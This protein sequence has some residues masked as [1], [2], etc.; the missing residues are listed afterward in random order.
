MLLMVVVAVEEELNYL[1]D[2][3]IFYR[4][5]IKMYQIQRNLNVKIFDSLSLSIY[6]CLLIPLI[7]VVLLC[8]E[9]MCFF[10]LL[11]GF[12]PRTLLYMLNSINIPS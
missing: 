7:Q 9:N 11:F 4:V 2:V 8:V 10:L 1:D 5:Y 3:V 6:A 12:I